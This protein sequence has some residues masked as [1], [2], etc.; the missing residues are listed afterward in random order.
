M[1]FANT[2]RDHIGSDIDMLLTLE[3]KQIVTGTS[4]RRVQQY[5]LADNTEQVI[6]VRY[7]E[8]CK[9]DIP[10]GSIVRLQGR[11]AQAPSGQMVISLTQISVADRSSIRNAAHLL[12]SYN[13]AQPIANAVANIGALI[14]DVRPELRTFLNNV[15]LDPAIR[16]SLLTAPWGPS[17]AESR[18]GG[19]IATIGRGLT[20][21][22]LAGAQRHQHYQDVHLACIAYLCRHLGRIRTAKINTATAQFLTPELASLQLLAPH[23]A[24]LYTTWADGAKELEHALHYLA[25]P[26]AV[27]GKAQYRFA[28]TAAESFGAPCA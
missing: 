22:E 27:R 28:E 19:L 17:F 6:G 18:P 1:I 24:A 13:L 8:H 23:L 4:G 12:P 10:D 5:M 20:R 7:A 14:D 21:C 11:I 16:P 9:Q 3:R 25:T 2:L 26:T 15:L